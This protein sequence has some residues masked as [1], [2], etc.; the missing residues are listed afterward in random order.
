M[1]HPFSKMQVQ[2]GFTLLEIM[3]VLALIGLIMATVRFTVFSNNVEHEIQKEVQRLQV[4]FSMASDYAVINQLELGLRL[5][6][7][8]QSYEFV[9]LGDQEKWVPLDEANHFAMRELPPGVTLKVELEGLAWQQDDSLFD[10]R[11]F[12]EALSIRDESVNIGPEED[13]EPPPP[14]IFILSSGEI[15]P[16]ELTIDYQ[17]Q[18]SGDDAFYFL[19]QGVETV[20][21]LREGPL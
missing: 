6:E 8:K 1:N 17:S 19:L 10:T 4:I 11:I 15:T 21:L 14:Q 2:R 13:K 5:D 3:L 16:F 7:E 12:D 9:K 18:D 20:P